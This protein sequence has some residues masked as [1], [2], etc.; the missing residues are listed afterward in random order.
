CSAGRARSLYAAT[1]GLKP[2]PAPPLAPRKRKSAPVFSSDCLP[3]L[4][5]SCASIFPFLCRR[6]LMRQRIRGFLL[7]LGACGVAE[8]LLQTR[9]PEVRHEGGRLFGPR[10]ADEIRREHLSRKLRIALSLDE[11][12]GS[13]IEC[14]PGGLIVRSGFYAAVNG[15]FHLR[16]LVTAAVKRAQNSPLECRMRT[17]GD[18]FLEFS[19]GSAVVAALLVNSTT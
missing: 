2:Q 15:P 17:C 13:V 16:P 5:A 3:S 8:L 6:V 14:N 18:S 4:P 12:A 1:P 11:D 19:F 10:A 7:P 9:Q